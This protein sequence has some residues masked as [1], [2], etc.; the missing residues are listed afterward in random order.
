[1]KHI[2]IYEHVKITDKGGDVLLEVR[3][4]FY[5]EKVQRTTTR[6]RIF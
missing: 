2:D 5:T 6:I 1:M 3:N 4:I